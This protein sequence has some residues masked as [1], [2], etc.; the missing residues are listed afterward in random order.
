MWQCRV[1]I[2]TEGDLRLHA[3]DILLAD[4]ARERPNQDKGLNGGLRQERLDVAFDAV[5]GE[6]GPVLVEAGGIDGNDRGSEEVNPVLSA[7]AKVRSVPGPAVICP[8]ADADNPL[9]AELEFLPADE[10]LSRLVVEVEIALAEGEGVPHIGGDITHWQ[11][12]SMGVKKLEIAGEPVRRSHRETTPRPCELV[13]AV[14]A[15][16]VAE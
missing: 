9:V 5:E 7:Q 1:V 15:W 4:D 11:T 12:K 13:E 2:R 6:A 10:E 8:V 3:W 16:D 14:L